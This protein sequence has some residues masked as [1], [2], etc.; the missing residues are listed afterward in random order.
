MKSYDKL[1]N[2]FE[3]RIIKANKNLKE[4]QNQYRDESSYEFGYYTGLKSANMSALKFL[5]KF[6]KEIK[7]VKRNRLFKIN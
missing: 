6:E 2:Y 4:Y 7:N 5:K 1:Q 3:K